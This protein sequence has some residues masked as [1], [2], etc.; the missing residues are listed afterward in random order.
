MA[1]TEVQGGGSR[2]PPY[3]RDEDLDY[4]QPNP[5]CTFAQNHFKMDGPATVRFVAER[6]PGALGDGSTW[7]QT[8]DRAE[9]ASS[10]TPP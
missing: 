4:K 1:L 8:S 9:G 3:P 2:H 5:E 10:R 7:R 6:M